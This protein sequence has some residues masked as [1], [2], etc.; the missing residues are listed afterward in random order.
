MRLVP[1]MIVCALVL[2]ATPALADWTYHSD[3]T[4]DEV[5]LM[6]LLH[7]PWP[8]A[9]VDCHDPSVDLTALNLYSDTGYI[10][11]NVGTAWLDGPRECTEQTHAR[12]NEYLVTFEPRGALLNTEDGFEFRS[13]RTTDGWRACI[14][15]NFADGTDSNCMGVGFLSAWFYQTGSAPY[16]DWNGY[17][18]Y[19]LRGST[20]DVEAYAW[21]TIDGEP[22]AFTIVDRLTNVTFETP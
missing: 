8:D 1:F 4:G 21:S 14:V 3:A 7:A 17:R 2:S 10:L 20:Y 12:H 13:T 6:P 16:G 5:A 15:I 18:A 19:D 11:V 9:I 22:S